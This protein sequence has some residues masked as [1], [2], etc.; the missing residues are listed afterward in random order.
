MTE[1]DPQAR[2]FYLDHL[3]AAL[4][5]LVVLHHVALVYGAISPFYY[6]EPPF[7]D[8]LAF[9]VLGTFVLLNQAWFMG[10]LFL[11]AGYFTPGSFER[12]GAAG[13]VRARL[14][15]LGIPV[16]V[17]IFVLEPVARLGFWLM[18]AALTGI[19]EPPTWAV[20]PSLLGLGPLWFVAML[21]VFDLAY[22]GWWSVVP[23]RLVAARETAFPGLVRIGGFIVGLAAVSYGVRFIVPLGEE[24]RLGFAFLNFPT[25][26][27]LPQYLGF[28]IL[29]VVAFRR[30]W[31]ARL[32]DAAGLAGLAA[33]V[34]VGVVLLPLALTGQW[35]VVAFAEGAPFVGGGH[36]RSAVYAVW[37]SVTVVGL[38]L[39][40]VVGFRRFLAVP[41]R[42]GRFVA[43]QSY[44][45][46]I[47]H[48]LVIV[49]VAFLLRG[50]DV[51][52]LMKFAVVAVIVVPVCFA[53]AYGVRKLPSV[54][55][56]L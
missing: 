14:V 41:G 54:A 51:P 34:V 12:R 37:D 48:S 22:A 32:P 5:A 17:G 42:F 9:T 21:L 15:R 25:I 11:L 30:G 26:A 3:R 39:A 52:A 19:T 6:Q 1:G 53:V 49:A 4:V 18:P 45:V 16:V 13:F 28:F 38:C 50:L 46:Y 35:F 2:L 40:L 10:A 36:W 55:R 29:G 44:A 43:A 47:L 33:A 20:Y 56:V 7:G 27:Y 8:G 24:V 31:L 23:G